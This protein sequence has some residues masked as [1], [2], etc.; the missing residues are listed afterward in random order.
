M[1]KEI[2]LAI[3]MTAP[4]GAPEGKELKVAGALRNLAEVLAEITGSPKPT[5]RII[6]DEQS[7]KG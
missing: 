1:S 7:D 2:E 3:K 6:K 4:P 5:M